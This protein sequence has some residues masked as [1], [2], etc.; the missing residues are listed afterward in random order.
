M[1]V[2]LK[3]SERFP[4][5]RVRDESRRVILSTILS[6]SSFSLSPECRRERG[7]RIRILCPLL[8]ISLLT[9]LL[10]HHLLIHLHQGGL[11]LNAI[12]SSSSFP[13]HH[14]HA[15]D[16]SKKPRDYEREIRK[17]KGKEQ[18]G[19]RGREEEWERDRENLKPANS[20][21]KSKCLFGWN[22]RVS[23]GK[24][25]E[26]GEP[27]DQRQERGEPEQILE[28]DF[29]SDQDDDFVPPYHLAPGLRGLILGQPEFKPGLKAL[30]IDLS[31]QIPSGSQPWIDYARAPPTNFNL[32]LREKASI[33]SRES[34]SLAPDYKHIDP[35]FGKK[36]SEEVDRSFFE[37]VEV[38]CSRDVLI[39]LLIWIALS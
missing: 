21:M 13:N 5:R 4:Q 24:D 23:K 27:R 31:V 37:R 29:S 28:D 6:P 33:F 32:F 14:N 9:I 30:N 17:G 36:G 18:R 12:I 11:T 22:E 19:E 34:Q 20:K 7:E 8:R 16:I 2:S 1:K 39:F 35:I 3:S 25:R 26:P 10:S 38:C 15:R